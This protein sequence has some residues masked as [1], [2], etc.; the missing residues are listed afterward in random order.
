LAVKLKGFCELFNSI[1]CREDVLKNIGYIHNE[2]QH[3][4]P[5]SDGNNRVTRLIVNWLLIKF[6]FP[7]LVLKKGSFD[8][9]MS[10]TKLSVS[11]KDDDLKILLL[12]LIYHEIIMG[13]SG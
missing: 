6:G 12:H 8:K 5:F 1:K 4:H 7:L 10:L 3:L 11:R 9:Y 13:R 2:F